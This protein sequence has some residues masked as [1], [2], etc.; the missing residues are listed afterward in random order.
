MVLPNFC[1]ISPK[2]QLVCKMHGENSLPLN[3]D[4]RHIFGSFD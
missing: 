3:V 1:S 2:K 4:G